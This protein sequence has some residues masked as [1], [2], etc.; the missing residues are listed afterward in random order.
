MLIQQKVFI[1]IDRYEIEIQP[2]AKAPQEKGNT[3]E[4]KIAIQKT[5]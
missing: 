2:F 3:D 4:K 5:P 1:Q